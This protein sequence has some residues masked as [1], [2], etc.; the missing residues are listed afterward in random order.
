M[1]LLMRHVFVSSFAL[2]AICSCGGG[3]SDI[4]VIDAAIDA[5]PV[6]VDAAIDG[7]TQACAPP[8][9][10]CG[11][12]CSDTTTDERYCGNCATSCV[13]GQV[14]TNS[15]CAC[16]VGLTIPSS[17]SFFMEQLSTALPGAT[18]GIGPYF[19]S[20]ID[21]LVVGRTTADTAINTPHT[22]DGTNLGTP[23]FVAFGYDIDIATRMPSAAYY[24]TAG[25]LTFTKI[26]L[27]DAGTGQ[28]AGFSGTLSG[29]TFTA[30][31]GLMNPVLVPGGCSFN[32][33]GP[34]AFTYGNVT[35]S[36]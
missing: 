15:T 28:M 12:D 13:G 4:V 2:A 33:A 24:A 26:C 27:A 31:E 19:G 30:V 22:L 18:I 29:A 34:V 32:V 25:T 16:A 17:P 36:N 9:M 3:G 6:V 20:T 35:C 5:T 10:M 14:C 8:M 1:S 11:P 7:P 21:A 23:P